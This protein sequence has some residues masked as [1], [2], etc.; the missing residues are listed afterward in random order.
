MNISVMSKFLFLDRYVN[1]EI[2]KYF[3]IGYVFNIFYN[4]TECGCIPNFI[5]GHT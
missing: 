4:P 1:N 3:F 2:V 5:L